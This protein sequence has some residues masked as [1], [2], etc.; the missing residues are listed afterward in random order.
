M[1]SE[2]PTPASRSAP[3]TW[4]VPNIFLLGTGLF[5][6]VMW[7][8]IPT[9]QNDFIM[10]DDPL[11]V[12]ANANVHTGLNFASLRWAM[13]CI[14]GANWHPLT[15]L[16]HLLDW[17]LFGAQPWGHHL[18]SVVLHS[19]NAVLLFV[20]L[21]H[22][23]GATWRSLVVALFF[24]LHPLRV[25][26]VAWVAERKDVLSTFFG[27]LSLIFYARYAQS[28]IGNQKSGIRNYLAALFFF[29]LGLMSKPMLVTWPFVLLL[30][31]YWPL[32]RIPEFRFSI[33]DLKPLLIGKIPFLLLAIATSTVTYFVQGSSGAVAGFLTVADRLKGATVSYALYLGKII[34]PAGLGVFYP[35]ENNYA[36]AEIMLAVTLL[37][38]IS[39]FVWVARKRWPFCLVGWFWFVGMMVPVIGLVHVGDQS[40]ADRYTYLPLVG[41]AMAVV[42]GFH[43]LTR[44]WRVPI[45]PVAILVFILLTCCTVL[46]RRQIGYWRSDETLFRHTLAVTRDNYLAHYRI[47]SDVKNDGKISEAITHYRAALKI[48]PEHPGSYAGLGEA[49]VQLGRLNEGL[50]LCDRALEL[51]P[52]S[53][54]AH[55]AI[56]LALAETGRPAEA[57]P[58][59]ESVLKLMPE[60]YEDQYNLG[61]ALLKTARPVE[62]LPHFQES[63]RLKPEDPAA[64]YQLALGFFKLGRIPEAA[65]MF[66]SAL[67]IAPN[68]VEAQNDFAWL[69]ATR[70]ATEGGNP[71]LAL[72]LANRACATT[73]NVS[74]NN[75]DTLAVAYAANGQFPAAITNAQRAIGLAETVGQTQL[76]AKIRIRLGLFQ[77]HQIY[78]AP[79]AAVKSP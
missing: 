34:W 27:L 56:A 12:V 75:L 52:D 39:V 22:L 5:L 71:K 8:F 17:Q 38:G 43:G 19:A 58:H 74:P 73:T 76:V 47:A 20:A 31:D 9:L 24:G 30:L 11:Y 1:K 65:A 59:F 25:E 14:V 69:L 64:R 4:P 60:E 23:T 49:L 15:M 61:L 78:L 40:I 48:F 63:L 41:L 77:N 21:R 6:V 66:Q 72:I 67:Q 28:K 46:T 79:A 54:E 16:S 3:A 51:Q 2:P 33:S 32:K 35:F 37:A 44:A 70:P 10:L 57:I 55:H 42:W 36:A 62:A 26:S 68:F 7:V 50:R 45:W 18:T 29:A 13:T 53:I